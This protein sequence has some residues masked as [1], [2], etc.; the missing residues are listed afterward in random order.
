MIERRRLEHLSL[1]DQE[2]LTWAATKKEIIF[3]GIIDILTVRLC[4]TDLLNCSVAHA[5]GCRSSGQEYR[6]MKK[7]EHF[8]MGTV[9]GAGKEIS[10][11]P[12]DFY[13]DR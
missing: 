3:F 12:S 7:A 13:G 9:K 1:D 2:R 4:I 5:E 10:C 8:F 11:Q 6:K